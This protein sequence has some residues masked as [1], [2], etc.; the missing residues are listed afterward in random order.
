[1]P[2]SRRGNRL[3]W[4]IALL[5]DLQFKF[6]CPASPPDVAPQIGP[7][8]EFRAAVKGNRP[9]GEMGQGLPSLDQPVQAATDG[10]VA[11]EYRKAAAPLNS[12]VTLAFPNSSCE[13]E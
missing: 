13:T 9:A 7:L 6:R 12:D 10:R 2:P 11:L 4:G 8:G 3:P 1:M 5:D